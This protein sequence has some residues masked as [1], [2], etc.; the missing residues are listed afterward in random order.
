MDIWTLIKMGFAMSGRTTS[1][2][3]LSDRHVPMDHST[4][5]EDG[6]AKMIAGLKALQVK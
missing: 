6:A 2:V 5:P 3:R 1:S 4:Q